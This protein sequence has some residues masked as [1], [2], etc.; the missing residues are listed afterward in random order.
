MKV[1]L[2][3]GAYL[4]ER[5]HSTDA[6]LDL[7]TT[8]RFFLPPRG[9]VTVD[10]GVHVQLPNGCY[11]KIEGKSGLAQY[12]IMPL[13]GVVDEGYSGSIRV[14]LCNLSDSGRV[15]QPGEKIAQLLVIPCRYDDCVVADQI[16]AG[17]RGENGFGSTG[18]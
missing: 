14:T 9:H 1:K 7:R 4:P 10:T 17:E 2:D 3:D 15:F 5:A 13:G 12:G 11:G 18:K 6:G 8:D 16:E